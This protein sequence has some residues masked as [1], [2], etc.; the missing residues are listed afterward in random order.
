MW[1]AQNPKT[2]K[3]HE[4]AKGSSNLKEEIVIIIDL[5]LRNQHLR[6]A[7]QKQWAALRVRKLRWN[8]TN[9]STRSSSGTTRWIRRR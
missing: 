9:C 7:Q 1:K 4:M 2:P 3:P 5:C 8:I 6:P